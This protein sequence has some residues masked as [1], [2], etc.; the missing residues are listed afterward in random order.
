MI[1]DA[2]QRPDIDLWFSG[3]YCN[4]RIIQN[5]QDVQRIWA[6]EE[7][8][9]QHRNFR[10]GRSVRQIVTEAVQQSG[11]QLRE[12]SISTPF[13]IVPVLTIRGSGRRNH[14]SKR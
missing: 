2:M 11:A 13:G 5:W 3:S 1:M 12:E 8:R 7:A 9:R 6:Q 14:G 10:K 4:I